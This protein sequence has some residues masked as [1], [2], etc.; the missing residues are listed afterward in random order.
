MYSFLTGVCPPRPPVPHYHFVSV[1]ESPLITPEHLLRFRFIFKIQANM[2]PKHRDRIAFVRV[3]SGRLSG[4]WSSL[5]CS[6]GRKVRLSEFPPPLFGNERGDRRSG[7]PRRHHRPGRTRRLWDWRHASPPI[8]RSVTTRSRGS[9]RR[10]S[11]TSTIPIP[12]VQAVPDR[13]S[14]NPSSR[15]SPRRSTSRTPPVGSPCW[16]PGSAAV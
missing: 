9:P 15:E 10:S 5:M 4:T 13:V 2:D 8:R 14:T 16:P 12:Q 6:P 7:V 1:S 3:V 11:N